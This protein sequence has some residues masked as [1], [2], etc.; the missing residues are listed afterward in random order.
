MSLD[1]RETLNR[2][3]VNGWPQAKAFEEVIEPVMGNALKHCP[4][5]VAFGEMVALL[6]QE[7]RY[8]AAVQL[9]GLWNG[10]AKQHPFALFCAYP[11]SSDEHAPLEAL[12]QVCTAHERAIPTESYT[13]LPSA[14]E[15]LTAICELQN[16]ARRL[17]RELADRKR[18]EQELARREL[19]LSDFLENGVH[20]L[21]RVGRDGT[22]LWA[23]R[24]ELD[25]LGYTAAEYVGHDIREFHVDAP[26]IDGILSCLLAGE[27]VRDGPARLRCK[28]GDI[29]H[30]LINSNG[31]WE[32]GTFVHTRCF[33][34]DITAQVQAEE[35]LRERETMLRLAMAAAKVGVWVRD[36]TTDVVECSPELAQIFGI[37]AAS[38]K[39]SFVEFTNFLHPKDRDP[40]LRAVDAAIA[41][42]SD[43]HA[44]FRF[45][46]ATGAWNWMEA[47]GR[48]H[49]EADGRA[50]RIYAVAID[51]TERQRSEELR[52][53]AGAIV[54]SS[55][56]AIVS[57]TLTGE[58]TSWNPGAERVFGYTAEEMIGRPITTVIPAELLHEEQ[59]IL[60]KLSRGERIEHYETQRVAK[61][62][63]RLDMSISISPVRDARGAIVGASKV[64]RDISER[65]RT[66]RA[67]REKEQL[68]QAETAALAKLN[69]L[70][71]RLWRAK[72]LSEGLD[73]MLRALLELLGADKGNI[74]LLDP[75][76]GMLTIRAQIGFEQDFR[77]FF[78]ELAVRGERI[79]IEDVDTDASFAPLRATAHA[80]G[81]R[82][83]IST[84][85]VG[86]DGS[87]LGIAATHFRSPHRPTEQQLRRLDLYLRQASDFIQRC[88]MEDALRQHA[89]AMRDADRRKDEFLALLAHELRNPLAPIRYAL[90]AAKKSGRTPE[91]MRRVDEI[92]DRQVSHMSR[93]LDDLLD[94]SRITRGTLELKKTRTELTAVIAM[95]IEAARPILDTKRHTLSVDLTKEPV[96]IDADPVRLAQV[97]S[98][99]VINAGKYTDPDGNIE[100]TAALDGGEIVVRVRD[101]GI[102]ISPEMMPRL[103]T[104]FS[105]AEGALTRA[106]GGLGI[107][108]ALARGLIALHGGTITAH[109]EGVGRGSEFVVRL[110]VTSSAA[111][112]DEGDSSEAVL[113]GKSLRVLVA[114]DNR[115]SAMSC[116]AFLKLC[117][118]DVQVAYSGRSALAIADEFR[119]QVILLDIGMPEMAGYE[120]AQRLRGKSWS[121]RTVLIAVTGWGQERDKERATAAGFDHHLTKPVDPAA[122]ERLLQDAYLSRVNE[123]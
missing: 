1:A 95:A 81:F 2:F 63:R 105:Q 98:N 3:L 80:A 25:L 120:V 48:A 38:F 7:G 74:Q 22:I 119:P 24:A 56:D 123:E 21:H 4:R 71:T 51:V 116:S 118:H 87:A 91:Q 11:L 42:R 59:E 15:R 40:L 5:L 66:D 17:E 58:V 76:S 13:S 44:E 49:Y 14:A 101:N 67:M 86:A 33:T 16:R 10:L 102:G 27:S 65:K 62:G 94:V 72:S 110:P 41:A 47:R 82:A 79:I 121:A 107:G 28:N 70:S 77:D 45:R 113:G 108:L 39:K 6:W 20:P 26:A 8:G 103:F 111:R 34:R 84:P 78:R 75:E 52:A 97:F 43:F 30:V 100:L 73:E 117:G 83:V 55:D 99:L 104:M 37:G 35:A 122:L 88:A 89:Q 90:A 46:H 32:N 57:K 18:L 92:I 19:E 69:E 9:E 106:E 112:A 115:D 61:D 93:L 96:R 68:L 53:L 60:A 109:S 36:L 50:T 114:D 64:A 12:H 31:L 85:L 29:K 54:E 23:N